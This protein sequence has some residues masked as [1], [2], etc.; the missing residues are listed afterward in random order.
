MRRT[1]RAGAKAACQVLLSHRGQGKQNM[2]LSLLT[3]CQSMSLYL[4]SSVRVA[5]GFSVSWWPRT[6]RAVTEDILKNTSFVGHR[7]GS[8]KGT[9]SVG[10]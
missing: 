1:S 6:A 3:T 5:V 2:N 4:P 10:P 8:R 9:L 7:E